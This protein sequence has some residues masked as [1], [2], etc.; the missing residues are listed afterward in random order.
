MNTATHGRAAAWLTDRGRQRRTN[1]DAVR[2]DTE[3]E[4][5]VVADGLGGL[6]GG[7]VAS[8]IAMES[9]AVALGPLPRGESLDRDIRAAIAEAD[10]AVRRAG[11]TDLRLAGMG[12]TVVLA[13]GAGEAWLVAHVGDSRAYLFRDGRLYRLTT[14]HN[15]AA[16]LVAAGRITDAEAQHHPGRNVVTRTL[17]AATRSDPT[18]RRVLRRDGDR[19]LL[20]T[21][22]LTAVLDD[23]TIEEVFGRCGSPDMCCRSLVVLANESGGPDNIT[24]L[25]TDI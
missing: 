11:A 23:S 3:L 15:V 10:A 2:A 4:V 18:L 19:L 20:C 22:G 8:R 24:I 14:D 25:I 16:E 7:E 17:G 12:T 1:E 5:Y 13:V 21:D 6:P 9:L